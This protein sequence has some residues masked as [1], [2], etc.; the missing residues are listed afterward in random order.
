MPFTKALTTYNPLCMCAAQT[1]PDGWRN[2]EKSCYLYVDEHCNW[3]DAK[4]DE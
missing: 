3:L 4:V 1:C 2:F